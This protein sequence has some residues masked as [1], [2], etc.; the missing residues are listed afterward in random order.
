M[1]EWVGFLPFLHAISSD[2]WGSLNWFTEMRVNW[3]PWNRFK[4]FE[5]P[6]CR[7]IESL[8]EV[9]NDADW[10]N[11]RQEQRCRPTDYHERR[12]NLFIWI[13]CFLE[14]QTSKRKNTQLL[15]DWNEAIKSTKEYEGNEQKNTK[16]LKIVTEMIES[17]IY[18]STRFFFSKQNK[19]QI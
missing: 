10:Q 17:L 1:W 2:G 13:R 6:W 14:V 18:Y 19:W 8:H 16:Q 12:Q 3:T 15:Y 7:N 4:T 11:N 5:L 9:I